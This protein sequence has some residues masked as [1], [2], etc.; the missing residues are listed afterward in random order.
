MSRLDQ[1]A[2]L[3]RRLAHDRPDRRFTANDDAAWG[4]L[5]EPAPGEKAAK[6][7]TGMR[8][9]LFASMAMG[10]RAVQTVTAYEERHRERINLVGLVTDDPANAGAKISL[11]RRLWQYL[12]ADQRLTMET[13]TIETALERG[14]SVY[15]GEIKVD[16][17]RQWARE[18][19]PDV[20]L[21]CGLGQVLDRVLIDLPPYGSYNFHPADLAHHH[22]A[23]AAPFGDIAERDARTTVWS[24]H[25]V[26]EVVDAGPVIGQSPPVNIRD[27]EGAI[28]DT[29]AMF[30]KMLE[31]LPTMVT[32]LLDTLVMRF[33]NEQKGDIDDVDFDACFPAA[34]KTR[35][36][37]PVA[38]PR[39][40][41]AP[42]D[43]D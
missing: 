38:D 20:I 21:V 15:T 17:F 24:V 3:N 14:T 13:A 9:L 33:E 4:E 41:A 40:P 26:T 2:R 32:V 39:T 6:R 10:L 25:Q 28:P 43:R 35:I 1:D 42:T 36:L 37:E 27:T 18:R 16:W 5:I 31:P 12:D 19:R 29:L 7:D 30:E 11:K 23:G 8:I 34:V 22:G